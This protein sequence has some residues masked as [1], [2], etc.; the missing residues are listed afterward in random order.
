MIYD[1]HV[2]STA[3]P[4]GH[5]LPE[6]AAGFYS[7]SGIGCI[8]TD[9]ADYDTNGEPY[10]CVDFDTFPKD[11]IEYRGEVLLLGLEINLLAPCKEINIKRANEAA[12]D[13]CIGSVHW[14][15]DW[16][17]MYY[18]EREG[19][20]EK[21]AEEVYLKH[22]SFM[23]EMVKT[24]DFYDSLGHIDYVSRYSP[25]NQKDLLYDKYKDIYD[26]IFKELISKDKVLE[27]NTARMGEAE[28]RK[29]LYTIYS[30]YKVL[31]GRYVT[32]GSDAHKPERLGYKFSEALDM[33]EEIGLT[34]VYF[35]ERR[36]KS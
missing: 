10:F 16:G 8:F 34:L 15:E 9:H 30:R 32:I 25:L 17:D 27:V 7:K 6:E 11:F 4:D 3:S 26:A 14:T 36:L 5:I 12:I 24:N 19:Y 21:F 23:L 13:Y 1:S 29:N 22:L 35:K 31:G 2:H 28:A 20:Y 18:A 33:I